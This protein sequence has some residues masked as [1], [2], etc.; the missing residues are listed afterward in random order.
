[1]ASPALV[2]VSNRGPLSFAHDRDGHLVT[3]KA[4]GGLVTALGPAVEHTGAT[5]VAAA[6]SPGDREAAASLAGEHHEIDAEGFRVKLLVVEENIYRAFYDVVANGVLWYLHHGLFDRP[7]RPRFDRVFREAWG[8]F[9][10]VNER[11]A[12][13]TADHAPEGATVIVHDYHLPLVGAQL[14]EKRPD[15]ETVHFNHTPFA[16]PEEL[17]ILPDDVAEELLTGLAGFGACG[18]HSVRWAQAFEACCVAVLGTSVSTFVSPATADDDEIRA[19]ASGDECEAALQRLDAQVGDRAFIVRVDRTELSKNI[20]RGFHAFDD[21]LA[22]YPQ[23]RGRVVF[24]AFVYPTR[25]ALADYQAYAAEVTT[26]AEQINARWG[27]DDWTPILLD[28]D[29]DFPLSVAAL[30][31]YDVLLVNPVRDGLNLVAKEGPIV[32]ER[33]GLLVLSRESGVWDELGEVALGVNPYD[34]SGTADVMHEALT[35]PKAARAERFA[36]QRA[37]A[38]ARSAREWLDDSVRNARPPANL[39]Q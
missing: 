4:A 5:W 7:R 12:A 29:D 9:R 30:R 25:E 21:L 34:V 19:I 16:T 3:K 18:F 23:W 24:G 26:L 11:F 28:A 6:I 8:L 17:R 32:N 39:R 20:L 1:M 2:V 27:N 15:L 14:A 10:D 37:A 38:S 35:M 36:A 22:T 13:A 31:R 33:D